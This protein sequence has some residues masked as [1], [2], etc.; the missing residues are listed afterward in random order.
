ML[1]EGT[2]EF[3][4]KGK[5]SFTDFIEKKCSAVGGFKIS[6]FIRCSAGERPFFVTNSSLS[7]N[8]VNRARN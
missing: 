3:D 8:V 1:L 4:L 5:R 2:Q 6:G 7:N